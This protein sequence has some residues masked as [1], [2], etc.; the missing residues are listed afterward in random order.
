MNHSVSHEH[1]ADEQAAGHRHEHTHPRHGVIGFTLMSSG[2]LPRLAVAA[3]AA[4]ILWACIA[5]A[6]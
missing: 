6:L 5:W 4:A 1:P 3:V 2:V